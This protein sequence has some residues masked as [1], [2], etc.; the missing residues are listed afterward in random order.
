[1]RSAYMYLAPFVMTPCLLNTGARPASFRYGPTNIVL[2]DAIINNCIICHT[3]TLY[4][5]CL[6]FGA[7]FQ[8]AL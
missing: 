4:C 6:N 5:S 8:K 1:M 2:T 3:T 7:M